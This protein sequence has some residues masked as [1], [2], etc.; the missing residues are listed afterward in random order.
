[1]YSQMHKTPET[2]KGKSTE[3]ILG[4]NGQWSF[5]GMMRLN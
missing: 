2:K 5:D 3:K 1:M 4:A